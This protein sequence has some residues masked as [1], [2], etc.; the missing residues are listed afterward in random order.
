MVMNILSFIE[1]FPTEESCQQHF[2][3]CREKEGVYCKKCNSEAHYWLQNKLQWQCKRCGFR[4]T[5]RS[6]I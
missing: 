5:L 3:I 1:K 2:K 6:F 4:T